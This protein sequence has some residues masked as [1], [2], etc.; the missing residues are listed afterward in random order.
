MA[1]ANCWGEIGVGRVLVRGSRTRGKRVGEEE[2][3]RRGQRERR[4]TMSMW[5]G[6][7]PPEVRLMEPK[8]SPSKAQTASNLG[9]TAGSEPD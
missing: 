2:K 3:T 5:S 6:E 9:S 7:R 4:W 8:R 1:I